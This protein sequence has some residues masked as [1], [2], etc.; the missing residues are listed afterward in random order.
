MSPMPGYQ[1]APSGY[2]GSR[3]LDTVTSKLQRQHRVIRRGV[4]RRQS[5]ITTSEEILVAN[6][7]PDAVTNGNRSAQASLPNVVT[8]SNQT[9]VTN[10]NPS[11]VINDNQTTVIS[12]NQ[13]SLTKQSTSVTNNNQDTLTGDTHLTNSN[14]KDFSASVTSN[15]QVAVTN[16]N[17]IIV[18]NSNQNTATIHFASNEEQEVNSH[19][20]ECTEVNSLNADCTLLTDSSSSSEGKEN[21][22]HWTNS[23]SCA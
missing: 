7:N 8:N 17:Q 22:I 18:T 5:A 1:A 23:L 9:E 6:R 2:H 14:Q 12:S 15:N 20:A 13:N 4:L 3:S 21:E 16:S 19:N 10:R 11:A